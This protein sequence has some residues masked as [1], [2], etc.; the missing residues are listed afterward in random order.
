MLCVKT[1]KLR[2]WVKIWWSPKW[3]IL[4]CVFPLSNMV[5][6]IYSYVKGPNYTL[7]KY[8]VLEMSYFSIK[9]IN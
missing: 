5:G 9:S 8:K 1:N 4:L 6:H 3:V 2:K 7:I